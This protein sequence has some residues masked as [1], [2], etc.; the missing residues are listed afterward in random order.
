MSEPRPAV[1]LHRLSKTYRLYTR[2]G[3]R[4]LDL[5]GLCPPGPRYFTEHVALQ[6]MDLTIARGEKVAI[7]GRNGAGKS[8]LLKLITGAARPTS[9]SIALHGRVSPLL[10]I[11]T[12]FHPEFTGRQNV[13]ASLAHMGVIGRE[14]AQRFDDIVDFAEL[15]QFIDQPMK[16]YST[17]MGARLMFSTATAV[18]PEILVVD[19]L[20]GVGDAYFAH[21]SFERMRALCTDRGTTLLLVTHDLYAAM[22]LCERFVWID[23][24]AVQ[25]VG[26]GRSTVSAYEAS[27][28]AQEEARLRA[29]NRSRAATA[30]GALRVVVRSRSGFALPEPLWI[31]RIELEFQDGTTAL[32]AADGA[33]DWHLSAESNLGAPD[34]IEG[35]RARPLQTFGHIYHKAEWTIARAT[36]EPP[37]AL[38]IAWRYQGDETAEV[39]VLDSENRTI[40]RGDLPRGEGWQEQRIANASGDAFAGS[41]AYGT[42]AIRIE[43]VVFAD[44]AGRESVS[45]PHGARLHARVTLQRQ[46]EDGPRD[47]TFVLAFN[48][49]GGTAAVYVHAGRLELP[50]DR[51]VVHVEADP[52]VLGGG[53]WLVT[54][55]VGER[56]LYQQTFNPYFTV[57]SRWYHMLVRAFEIQVQS[58][59]A[60][61]AAAAAMQPARITIVP[62]APAPRS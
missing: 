18:E 43:Q 38:R 40:L 30:G 29:R 28:K 12:G 24:G 15:D 20:L 4:I 22:D 42:G 57:N 10:Q 23:R 52:L 26:D 11:G 45:F 54:C 51:A 46:Q 14:A 62:D 34:T 8:T 36:S 31:E 16:T 59:S 5:L 27:I 9:G 19:E 55:A 48:R 37:A 49:L 53:A 50:A 3:Y 56:D 17:G 1:V 35:R 47:C 13:F 58:S 60:V 33:S 32:R 41:G 6:P 61:E 44:D 39:A 21:K 7:I 2:P 25:H